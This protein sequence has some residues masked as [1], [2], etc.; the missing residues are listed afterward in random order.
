MAGKKI[1]Q[2]DRTSARATEYLTKDT[3]AGAGNAGDIP[4]LNGSG[5]L[6][7]TIVNS[8]V[9]SAGAGSSGKIVALDGSG[10]I[11]P[12]AMPVG[13][14][15]D[16]QTMTASEA[17]S[18]G[19]FVNVWNN[20]GVAKVRNADATVA[21]K[22]AHG[23]VLAAIASG[24]AGAVYFEGTNTGVSA[25]LGGPV[26]LSTTAGVGAST[27]PTGSGNVQ[28]VLGFATSATTVNFQSEPPTVLV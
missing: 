6:D 21:G 25:Q 22:E 2:L 4:A 20:A 18:A 12:S 23:F 15:A 24:A 7:S 17:I 3:S 11:D 16:T 13:I 27:P 19:A 26:Y 10:R 1:L 5:V 28:Q 14:G 8:T 9:T